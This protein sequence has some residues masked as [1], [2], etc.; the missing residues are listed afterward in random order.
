MLAPYEYKTEPFSHQRRLFDATRELAAFALFWEQGAAKTKP[1]IDLA[2]DLWERGEIDAVVVV[3]PNG[4]HRNWK[5]DEI[6]AHLPDRLHNVARVEYWQSQKT[7]TKWFKEQMDELVKHK[8]FPWLLMSYNGFMTEVGKKYVWRFLQ[9]RRCLYILDEAHNIKPGSKRTR[10]IVASGVYAPWRRILT[11]TPI[12]KGPFDLYGQIKFLDENF[13]K[14]RGFADYTVFKFH[15]GQWIT[16]AQ[17][18]EQQGWDPGYDKLVG[19]KNLEELHGYVKEI[20]DRV[21]KE[22]VFDLPPKLYS[23]RYFEL[24]KEQAEAYVNLRDEYEHEFKDGARVDGALAI[25][26]LLRLHQIVCGYAATDDEEPARLLGDNNPMMDEIKDVIEGLSHPAIIWCR[27]TKD[28]DQVMDIV[29]DKGVRYDGRVDDDQREKNKL[30]FQHGEGPDFFVANMM[31]SSGLT[32]VRAKT[33]LFASQGYRLI[34]RLQAED[35]AHRPGMDE[36]PVNIIDFDG[37]LPSGEKTVTR[38]IIKNLRDKWDIAA[39]ITGD[40]LREWI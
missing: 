15:F 38:A 40:D 19:Y 33:E 35:R 21:L 25:T 8:G 5:S 6:P 3:A 9:K 39:Q 13:W 31:M 34:D 2:A 7:S 29:G 12:S 10:S 17:C 18:V 11:G 20:S 30:A 1:M 23:K 14:A 27:F 4:V 37:V 36:H 28:I 26:R 16:R 24:N 32:L 22:D